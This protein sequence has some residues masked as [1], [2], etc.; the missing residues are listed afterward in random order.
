MC[1]LEKQ[2]QGTG[3]RAAL[4]WCRMLVEWS[5]GD[6]R[7]EQQHRR[8]SAS[9]ASSPLYGGARLCQCQTLLHVRTLKP[10]SQ[11]PADHSQS[12][13]ASASRPYC[14]EHLALRDHRC[15]HAPALKIYLFQRPGSTGS[16]EHGTSGQRDI[17]KAAGLQ[18]DVELMEQAEQ[19]AV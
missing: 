9:V 6:G 17:S 7:G 16:P 1:G 14:L 19:H 4:C 10:S 15:S 12:C 8:S 5:G 11:P 18:D 13:R 2:W 3:L